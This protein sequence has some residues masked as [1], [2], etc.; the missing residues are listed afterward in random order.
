MH[1]QKRFAPKTAH[2]V[3]VSLLALVGACS[4]TPPAPTTIV[5]MAVLNPDVRPETID[6]TICIAGYTASV[7]PAPSYTNGVKMKLLRESGGEAANASKYELD[8]IV[9]LAV[10][11]HPRN[12]K[13][14]MLQPWDGDDGAKKKDRLEKRL[15][16]LVW[17]IAHRSHS[18]TDEELWQ[19]LRHHAPVR[20]DVAD[21]R[22]HPHVVFEDPPATL[23]VA[24]QVNAAHLNTHA[25]RRLDAS[26]FPMKVAG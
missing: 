11:G 12:L 20:D 15:Q 2:F 8:H 26:G 9:P 7:R 17:I 4:T 19:G 21:P 1:P 24:D 13:N 10:G 3:V 5:P 25:V 14:L 6:Q 22:R 18:H 23:L 16:Q